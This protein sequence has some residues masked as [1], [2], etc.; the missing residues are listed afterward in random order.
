MS[1]NGQLAPGELALVPNNDDVLTYGNQ[2]LEVEALPYFLAAAR[3]F[4]Q[5]TGRKVYLKEAYRTLET[6]IAYFLDR[7][8]VGTIGILW[9]GQRWLKKA[10]QATAAVPGTSI[11]GNGRAVDIWSGIDSSFVSDS[12]VV[13]VRVSTKYGWRNTGTGFGEPWHQEW[14]R[15]RVTQVLASLVDVTNPPSSAGQALVEIPSTPEFQEEPMSVLITSPRGQ[16]IAI[17]GVGVV[18]MA[19]SDSG[20]NTKV[21]SGPGLQ[22]LQT[23]AGMHA[24]IE[25]YSALNRGERVI[26][27]VPGSGFGLIEGRTVSVIKNGTALAQLRKTNPAEITMTPAEFDQFTKGL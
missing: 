25:F 11:H 8:F 17:P 9:R 15:A 27:S 18:P 13:W 26:V 5:A 6:Q 16:S 2:Y 24:R 20:D 19:P 1:S 21:T 12:H 10:N 7:Y 23:T 22:V 3:E 4:R 14:S